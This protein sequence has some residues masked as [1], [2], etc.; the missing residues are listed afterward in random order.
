MLVAMEM[1]TAIILFC[2]DDDD[3]DDDDHVL[4]AYTD[5][6]QPL[7]LINICLST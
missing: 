3:D 4:I 6:A 1:F 7:V 5:T 2:D